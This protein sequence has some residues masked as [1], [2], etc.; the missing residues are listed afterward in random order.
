MVRYY[1]DMWPRLSHV[2]ALLKEAASG[3]K[4]RK[5]FWNDALESYFKELKRMVSAETLLSYPDW[6]LSITVHTY[7]SDKQLGAVINQNNKPIDLCSSKL[8]KPHR[9]YTTT[10]KELLAIV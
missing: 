7:T 1:R 4:G 5:I 6:K 2:L 9:N 10:E 8:I 3:P